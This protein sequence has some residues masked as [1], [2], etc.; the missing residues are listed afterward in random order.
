MK[1]IATADWHARDDRPL[2]RKDPDWL[3][4]QQSQIDF[5]I[6]EANKRKA[7]LLIAGD[8]FDVPRTSPIVVNMLMRSLRRAE[9]DVIMIA[10]NHSLQYHNQDNLMNSSIGAFKYANKE[11]IIYL[12]CVDN[13]DQ[14]IFEHA[15]TIP[16][17]ENV[18]LIHTLVFPDEDE[19][20]YGAK[21]HDPKYIFKNYKGK[22]LI[23]GDYHKAFVVEKDG[24]Y[25]INPGCI[26]IQSADMLDYEPSIYYIDTD[27]GEIERIYIPEDKSVLTDNHI[28]EKKERDNR[29]TSFIETVKKHGRLSLSFTDNL[30]KAME[31]NQ[32][33]P[34]VITIIEEIAK[35]K[36]DGR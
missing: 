25:L 15:A 27:T 9:D 36:E 31:L 8:V 10:G 11:N 33:E 18:E 29:I 2:C 16:Y 4:T 35:E 21:A 30:R 17:N 13:T 14:G 1:I 7:K 26:N 23:T 22:Y 28:S 19:I 34:E 24:R 3:V 20:P 12:D 32:I 6:D 5:I